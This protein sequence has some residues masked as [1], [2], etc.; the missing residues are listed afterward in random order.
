MATGKDAFRERLLE[1]S[2]GA[3]RRSGV[4]SGGPTEVQHD[5]ADLYD[6]ESLAALG[7]DAGR[8]LG[9]PG[10][11]P[12]TRGVQPNMYRGRLWTMRQY[13]G[14]G[15][16]EE[17]NRRYRYL[18]EKGQ[19]GLSV[20]FDLPTQMGFDSD[21]ARAAGEVGRVGVAIDSLA[22]MRTLLADLPLDKVSTSMT[23]NATA[24]MLLA[25]YV[26]VAEERG[27]PR[28]A[29]RGTI[30][31]DI[32]KEYI[33]RGTYI[34]PPRPSLRLI[35]DVFAFAERE[36]PSWNTISIS[37]YH[38]RE[39]GCTA[40]QEVAFTLADGIAYVETAMQAGLDVDGFGKQLSF[41]FNG[42][43]NFIEE[44]AKFRAAR[45]LWARIMTE[46]FGAKNER[47]MALR[48]HCQ[49]AGVTLQAQQ[50]LVNV[51]RVALQAAAA[52]L[53]GCQSL[54]TNSYDEALGLPTEAAATL[55]LRTQQVIGYESGL[56]DF[57]DAMGGSYA[58]ESLTSTI[59]KGAMEYIARIDQLG[60]MVSAIEQGY[61]QREIQNAAYQ[62]Q[63]DVEDKRRIVVGQNEFISDTP[64][65]PVMK[66]DP[67]LERAQVERVRAWRDGRS[68]E[69]HA[70]ALA[71]IERTATG[72]D[73]LL[74]VLIDAVKAGATV[75]EMSDVLRRVWGEHRETLTL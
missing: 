35:R 47:A 58:V 44:I 41:F 14:F 36:L 37:G 26:A 70:H 60:G 31:N 53:G 20:A 34:F 75:G 4:L 45:R 2:R 32:L 46:R 43:N 55:A 64:P 72:D 57:V 39:A 49:T 42:H 33:A 12:F 48:F 13:A 29:L 56:A 21:H 54:H 8:D 38:M 50:P 40:V 24:P 74:P 68:S 19:T 1:A 25:L 61:V 30:Q 15:T 59:E 65:M 71:A 3:R 67:A 9:Y 11:P 22:D 17:S 69:A 62:Y 5:A 51:V 63:L 6:A 23:I 10:M 27:V 18:L 7:F 28:A 52:V 66:I 16:A 73:N